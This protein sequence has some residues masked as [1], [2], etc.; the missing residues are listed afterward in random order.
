MQAHTCALQQLATSTSQR[1]FN[2]DMTEVIGKV[3][4]HG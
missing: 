1:N 2:H 3:S 4:V